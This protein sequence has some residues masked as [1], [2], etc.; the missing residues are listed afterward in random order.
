MSLLMDAMARYMTVCDS[1]TI[2]LMVVDA[3]AVREL[4][5]ALQLHRKCDVEHRRDLL[6]VLCPR[7]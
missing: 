1:L 3:K 5:R 4:R 2:R 7:C 6:A